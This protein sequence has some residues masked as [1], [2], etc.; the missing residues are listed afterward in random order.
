VPGELFSTKRP[1]TFAQTV[2]SIN[3]KPLAVGRRTIHSLNDAV[4]HRLRGAL[5]KASDLRT[6]LDFAAFHNNAQ[7]KYRQ[8]LCRS[9]K[10]TKKIYAAGASDLLAACWMKRFI[11]VAHITF[12][13]TALSFTPRP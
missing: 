10:P 5:L 7:K 12:L 4:N 2:T 8:S 13:R 1:D 9:H 11:T 6:G 3:F